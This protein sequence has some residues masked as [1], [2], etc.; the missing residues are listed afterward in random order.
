[1]EAFD[2]REVPARPAH[3]VA[4]GAWDDARRDAVMRWALILLWLFNLEDYVLTQAALRSGA[5]ESNLLFAYV[6]E[7]GPGPALA[8]K[9]GVV[10][11][12]CLLL[13]RFRRHPATLVASLGLALA[14]VLVTVFHL[15]VALV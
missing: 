15:A 14:Y 2:D 3:G 8:F 7:Q 1:M 11:A 10:T 6:L 13:W 4:A 9:L 12:G 5:I